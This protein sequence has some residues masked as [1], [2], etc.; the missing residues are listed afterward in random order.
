MGE[1]NVIEEN[2]KNILEINQ[3]SNS[4]I[5]DDMIR[6]NLKN[7]KIQ[8]LPILR[9]PMNLIWM[10]LKYTKIRVIPIHQ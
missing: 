2:P 5:I 1:P 10:N 8:V 3:D 6:M 4:P 7:P 9:W